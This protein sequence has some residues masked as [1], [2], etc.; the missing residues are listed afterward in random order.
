[1][2]QWHKRFGSVKVHRKIKMFAVG[3]F[4]LLILSLLIPLKDPLFDIKYAT[5]LESREGH[6]LGA[7]IADDEQWRFPPLDSLPANYVRSLLEFED[8]HFYRHP[9][10][11]PFSIVRAV[12]QNL[13]EGRIVSGGST[14]TMQ[15]A[16]M[17]LGNKPRTVRQKLLEIWY[18]FRI[19]IYYSKDEI[20]RLYANNAPFGGNVV[21]IA[22]AAWRYYGRSPYDLSWAEAANL[23]V[24]PNAPGLAF[25][26]KNEQELQQ[27]RNMLLKKLFVNDAFS[28][29][30][31]M[32]SLDEPLPV[33][34]QPLPAIAP[35]LLDRGIREGHSGTTIMSTIAAKKQQSLNQVINDFYIKYKF[36]EIH[37]AA[38]LIA[39]IHT[40][41]IIAYTGNTHANHSNNHGQQV[42][43]ISSKRSPGSLLKPVLYALAIDRGLITPWELL[44]DI[45]VYYQGFAPQNF[46]KE[47]KGAV[48]ANHALRSSLNVPFVSLLREYSYEQFHFDL[49]KMGISSLNQPAG[50]YGLSIIL[51]GAEVTL[52]EMAGLYASLARNIFVY[53]ERKGERRYLNNN[54]RSLTY[55]K[56]DGI[57]EEEYVQQGILN[58]SSAWHMV[59]AM[60][61]LRRPDAES[62]WQQF[63]NSRAIAWKTG[64]S[65][66][67]KDAWAIGFNSQYVVAVWL[68]NADGEGRPDLTG[69]LTAAPVMFR[70]FE[71]LEGDAVFP[72]P[73]A[74]IKMVSICEQ[75]GS[76]ASDICPSSSVRPLSVAAIQKA[77]CTMHQMVNLD[78]AEKYKVHSLCYPVDKMQ[79][80]PWFV[81]PP[82]QAWYYKKYN[83]NY[84]EPPEYMAGCVTSSN[85]SLELIYPKSHTRV[86]VPIEVDG[87]PGKVVFEAAHR[88]PDARVFWFLDSEYVGETQRTHQLGLFP[89]PGTHLLTLS[90]EKGRELQVSFETINKRNM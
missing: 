47:F 11:N 76:I 34:P 3:S 30:T 77:S 88:N 67:H 89:E 14:I 58:V 66:G 12:R 51:G 78:A 43:I 68:G 33:K 53:N 85:E 44:P 75:S 20:L 37:N 73:V 2:R 56:S 80:K 81:L 61:E 13:K 59:K 7:R 19:E 32:L 9:G 60:Q 42:D 54:F 74:N 1:M 52:Y 6:L 29:S 46:N 31:F 21:G 70:A 41:E 28:E 38:A 63:S 16:R 57:E 71:L 72:M 15:V 79:Q 45:P 65:Y 50:H 36:K 90:D 64:T 5:V 4:V 10:V 55:I 26:G 86:Y 83:A 17:M 8:Q 39:D 62:N 27:K 49:K 25:P 18:A 40:G 82:A 87:R 22:A 23:A 69:I 35:H 24:L 48:P 84:T